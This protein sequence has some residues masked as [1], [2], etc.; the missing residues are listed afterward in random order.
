MVTLC[1]NNPLTER[2]FDALVLDRGRWELRLVSDG[3]P[4]GLNDGRWRVDKGVNMTAYL[5]AAAAM[6]SL[7]KS[8]PCPG[9]TAGTA[10]SQPQQA[11]SS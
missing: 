3:P 10:G 1:R 9:N 7:Y 6:R 5:R 2:A 11:A 4:P 8:P